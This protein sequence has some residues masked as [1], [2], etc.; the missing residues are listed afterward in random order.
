MIPG[1]GWWELFIVV[2]VALLV[3]GPKELPRLLRTVGQWT[4]QAQK[5]VREFRAGIDEMARDAEIDDLRRDIKSMTD[6]D[7][8]DPG[9][10]KSP[11]PGMKPAP[12]IAAGGSDG[13]DPPDITDDGLGNEAGKDLEGGESE[14]RDVFPDENKSILPPTIDPYNESVYERSMM[15]GIG[16][17]DVPDEPDLTDPDTAKPEKPAGEKALASG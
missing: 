16:T 7:L 9:T 17:E 3:V 13:A 2:S 6:I 5:M 15:D 14:G 4:Q 10:A 1:I 12:M 8:N 11:P